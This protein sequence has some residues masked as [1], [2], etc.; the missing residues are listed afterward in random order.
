M[1]PFLS[2]FF[3]YNATEET[4]KKYGRYP[5]LPTW[6]SAACLDAMQCL[7]ASTMFHSALQKIA[8]NQTFLVARGRG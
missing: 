3:D 7:G 4:F 8:A 1:L 2:R 6:S 5:G